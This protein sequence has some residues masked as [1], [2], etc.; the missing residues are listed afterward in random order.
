MFASNKV[1]IE[2]VD[3]GDLNASPVVPSIEPLKL[4]GPNDEERPSLSP[5]VSGVSKLLGLGTSGNQINDEDHLLEAQL[6]TIKDKSFKENVSSTFYSSLTPKRNVLRGGS[7]VDFGDIKHLSV[8]DAKFVNLGGDDIDEA[9]AVTR[10]RELL[11]SKQ[12]REHLNPKSIFNTIY[13]NK[14]HLLQKTLRIN[15]ALIKDGDAVGAN[16]VHV[17]YLYKQ[18][19]IGRWI[20]R[21]FPDEA[22]LPYS[23]CSTFTELPAKYMPYYGENVLHMC[24]IR[25][26]HTEVRF[27]L[28]FYRERLS[29]VPNVAKRTEALR[30]QTEKQIGTKKP[31]PSKHRLA[32]EMVD[33]TQNGLS[34]LLFARAKGTFFALDGEFYCGETPL[35]FAVCCGDTDMFDMVLS[36][37]SSEMPNALFQRDSHGNTL[38]HLCVMHDLS[39]MYKHVHAHASSRIRNSVVI[40][41]GD[42]MMADP[43]CRTP[44]VLE[45]IAASH[46]D[47][48]AGR[49]KDEDEQEPDVFEGSAP[50]ESLLQLPPNGSF[51]EAYIAQVTKK[52]VEER[53]TLVLNAELHSPLTFAASLGNIHMLKFL[54]DQLK[55]ERWTYGPVSVS[56][57]DLD[58]MERPHNLLRYGP[59]P[60][61]CGYT[62][63]QVKERTVQ[64]RS[65]SR[66]LP[67]SIG[68]TDRFGCPQGMRVHGAFEWLCIRYQSDP[69]CLD[70]F[71]IP[72]LRDLIDTKW[73]RSASVMF[74]RDAGIAV[75]I[76]VLL[77][78]ISC[79]INYHPTYGEEA[80]EGKGS[81]ILVVLYPLLFFFLLGLVIKEL[82]QVL[83]LRLDYWGFYG[84]IRG[85]AIYEKLC[86]T[87]MMV[88]FYVLCLLEAFKPERNYYE[89]E[90]GSKSLSDVSIEVCLVVSVMSAWS[91]LFYSFMGFDAT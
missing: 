89:A 86:M 79:L 30:K 37:T 19:G 41:C 39:E 61:D 1:G 38:L 11:V 69:D 10:I 35:Q 12:Q 44:P 72:F 91:Y 28:D 81:I 63:E 25:R 6:N 42:A 40:A 77:T 83:A 15:P 43:S 88:S 2:P 23:A 49:F 62:A 33:Y 9:K 75:V 67:A 26:A 55:V 85:A 5:L 46:F 48:S 56:L 84:G 18:Y 24:I 58:G 65:V 66:R 7:M 54:I 4:H 57:V 29:S 3:N 22:L 50:R 32:E 80:V 64:P 17:A 76:T 21:N 53:L 31:G 52:K 51:D 71:D 87:A 20:V 59:N 68:K 16:P 34:I 45:P 74:E 60:I 47:Y 82:P 36:Y 27:L 70:S 8:D 13:N 14:L 73:S 90:D 78:L